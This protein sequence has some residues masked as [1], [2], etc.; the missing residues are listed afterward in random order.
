LIPDP[1]NP[2]AWNRY[3]Y[4]GNRPINFNDPTGHRPT[5]GC[6]DDG[7]D[8]CHASDLEKSIN[9]QKLAELEYDPTG[10]KQR[11]NSAIAKAI[12]EDGS[13]LI[14]SALFE[15]ADWALTINDCVNG[16]CSLLAI[17]LMIIP[18]LNGRM[19]RY[20][21]EIIDTTKAVDKIADT[22]K[23]FDTFRDLKKF[24]GSP[25]DGNE[26]H[27][28][29][30]QSQIKKSGFSTRQINNVDNA[31]AV[32]KATHRKI[33]GYYSSIDTMTG[34][35]RVRDWLAGQSFEFQYDFGIDI[36]KRYGVIE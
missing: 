15:P 32:D 12:L 33:S 21:D 25:G 16:D 18:G 14:V 3:S 28:I 10:N 22:G 13:K 9:A 26:W 24:L 29:V 6:G 17:G 36:L 20:A 34:G 31:L 11:R 7:K 8:K 23:G 35:K 5:E 2:Q 1:S 27:H 4:V 19:G 30:E